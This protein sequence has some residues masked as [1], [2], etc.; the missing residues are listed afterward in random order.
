MVRDGNGCEPLPVCSTND[1][2]DKVVKALFECAK[3][4]APLIGTDPKQHQHNLRTLV[5]FDLRT[6]GVNLINYSDLDPSVYATLL[7][8]RKEAGPDVD[9]VEYA[10]AVC[11][12]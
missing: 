8:R 12:G 11:E 7:V 2:M 6:S 4:Y 1:H 3:D 9:S 10:V 5:E